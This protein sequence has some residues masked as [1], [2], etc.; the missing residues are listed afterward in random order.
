MKSCLFC[1]FLVSACFRFGHAQS[2]E[3]AQW[4]SRLATAPSD[5][6]RIRALT[7]LAWA[8]CTP[9]PDSARIL[10]E[11]GLAQAQPLQY[12]KGRLIALR[13]LGRVALIEGQYLQAVRLLMQ[14]RERASL[15]GDRLELAYIGRYLGGAY[16]EMRLFDRALANYQQAQQEFHRLGLDKEVALCLADVGL[17]RFGMGQFRVAQHHFEQAL[18]INRQIGYRPGEGYA[19]ANLGATLTELGLTNVALTKLREAEALYRT[20]PDGYFEGIVQ[21]HLARYYQ[22]EGDFQTSV[23]YAQRAYE[24]SVANGPR[25]LIGYSLR[26]LT[27]NYQQLGQYDQAFRALETYTAHQDTLHQDEAALVKLLSDTQRQLEQQQLQQAQRER[28][29]L[30]LQQKIYAGGLILLI[31]LAGFLIWNVRYLRR[32]NR[33]IE[34]QRHEIAQQRDLILQVQHQLAEANKELRAFNQNLESLVDQRT[35]ELLQANQ[36]LVRKNEEIRQALLDGQTIE[37]RRVASE[38]H[39]NLGGLLAAARLSVRSLDPAGLN[40]REREIYDGVLQ[41]MTDAYQEVRMISHNLLPEELAKQGLVPAL[42]RL[43]EKMSANSFTQ[44]F[45]DARPGTIPLPKDVAFHLYNVCLELATN[46]VKHA[47]AT[48]ATFTLLQRD[49]ALELTLQDD[50]RGLPDDKRSEGMGLR[51]IR[52]RLAGIGADLR[53]D[54]TSGQ[55]TSFRIRVPLA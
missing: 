30:A 44:F 7:E 3:V 25:Y 34:Q 11:Q 40:P 43:V 18:R 14:A 47:A 15:R 38:L 2:A 35:S 17:I 23:P 50:G 24:L 6:A 54:S 49:D 42:E 27:A 5:T 48:Q 8:Y 26:L 9:N 12:E 28:E 31:L 46:V 39:D 22:H 55:G 32:K 20:A 41:T 45:L 4:R 37:R 29:A 36:E 16:A 52:E 51:N 53:V 21:Y 10:A 1:F 33:K 13:T 19:L